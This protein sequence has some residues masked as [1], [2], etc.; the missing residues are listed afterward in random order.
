M[1]Q[2]NANKMLKTYVINLAGSDQRWSA[3]SLRLKELGVPFERF[4]AVDGRV[5]LHPLFDRYDDKLCERHRRVGLSGS[6]LGCFASHFKLWEKCLELDQPIVIME[7]DIII[8]A[9]FLE[10]IVVAEKKK[11]KFPYLR[12]AGIN[13]DNR[14]YKTQGKVGNFNLIDHVKG[15][16]GAQCYFLTPRA[17]RSFI[18]NAKIWYLAVDDYMDRYWRNGV[19]CL[20]LVPYPVIRAEFKTDMRRLTKR[21]KSL[22][23]RIKKEFFALVERFRRSIYRIKHGYKI[24]L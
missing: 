8:H 7:D 11:E 18:D 22:Y 15:P 1:K 16:S 5:N 19:R 3:T 23:F 24:Q 12:L 14:A 2:H 9:S 20:S 6:E 21:K 4:E 17:A 13:L 10:A